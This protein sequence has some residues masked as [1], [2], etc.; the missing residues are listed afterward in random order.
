MARRPQIQRDR[1]EVSC[2]LKYL[3]FSFNVFFWV[4]LLIL[5]VCTQQRV[6]I[7]CMSSLVDIYVRS[8]YCT[9]KK[10]NLSFYVC[11]QLHINDDNY[12]QIECNSYYQY[13]NLF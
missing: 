9:A 12:A 3:L 8:I 1:S 11:P 2:C 13:F 10:E 6:F 5:S 7:N 4:S